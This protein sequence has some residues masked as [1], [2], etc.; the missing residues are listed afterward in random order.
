MKICIYRKPER[1]KDG[2]VR[3]S[4]TVAGKDTWVGLGRSYR[5]AK[6]AA[7]KKALMAIK[8]PS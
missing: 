8:N 1:A 6:A 3:V 7:A 2:K 4:V 5:I